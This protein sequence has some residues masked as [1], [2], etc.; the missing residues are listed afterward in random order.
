MPRPPPPPPARQTVTDTPFRVVDEINQG[1]D[2]INERKV[3][4]RC[5]IHYLSPM[6]QAAAERRRGPPPPC[7][8]A[9]HC[10]N[11]GMVPVPMH[12]QEE[13][14]TVQCWL[15]AC[16]SCLQASHRALGSSSPLRVSR[17]AQA[18]GGPVGTRAGSPA[19]LCP[20]PAGPPQPNPPAPP[21][22]VTTT[23]A[24]NPAPRPAR[25]PQVFK[26]LVTASCAEGTPQCFLMTPKLLP[27][28]Q[29]STDITVL[30]IQNGSNIHEGLPKAFDMV[31]AGH[32]VGRL[33]AACE[34]TV[35]LG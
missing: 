21:S 33:A 3:R 8:L 31:G 10:E 7:V 26:Q 27:D 2:P 22:P 14:C 23:T 9:R 24:T 4:P 30:V 28:L 20:R 1:M 15:G 16:A 32:R 11:T 6:V 5:V 25:R 17:P 18:A 19:V 13:Y 29:Y 34:R 12:G 35:V